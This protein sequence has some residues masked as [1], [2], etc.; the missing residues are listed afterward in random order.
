MAK[1]VEGTLKLN[2]QGATPGAK[3][4]ST[5]LYAGTASGGGTG[6]FFVDDTTS[7]ELVSKSKGFKIEEMDE[8]YL[9][10]TP[11]IEGYNYWGYARVQ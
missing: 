2:D 3:A 7:D 1:E 10:K 5:L 8:M 6:V 4:G 9:P 11:K